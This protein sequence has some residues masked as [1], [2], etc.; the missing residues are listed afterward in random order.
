MNLNELWLY[1]NPFTGTIPSELGKL[2]NHLI[3]LRLYGT[4]L[5]GTVPDEIWEL[6]NLWRLDLHMG[7]FRGTISSDIENLESLNVFRISDNRFSGTLPTQLALLSS[8]NTLWLDGN[9]FVGS[10]PSG[11]CDNK[12]PDGIEF[13][14]ADCL[15]SPSGVVAVTCECCDSCC[16]I[17]TDE[18]VTNSSE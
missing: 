17:E 3:D 6:T 11:L 8:L 15:P 9:D 13:I 18:C 12:G 5:T 2:S 1:R 14:Q 7:S 10:V 16:S 4:D